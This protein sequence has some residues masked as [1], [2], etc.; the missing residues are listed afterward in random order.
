VNE[1]IEGRLPNINVQVVRA[2]HGTIADRTAWELDAYDL[3]MM[4]RFLHIESER[5]T[6]LWG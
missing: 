6:Y 1:H 4:D 3:P 5:H 2:V